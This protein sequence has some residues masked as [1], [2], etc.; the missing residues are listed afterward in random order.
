M[1]KSLLTRGVT[2]WVSRRATRQ[3]SLKSLAFLVSAGLA[4]FVP[5]ALW[6]Y[7]LNAENGLTMAGQAALS[8]AVAALTT[9]GVIHL[10]VVLPVKS[11]LDVLDDLYRGVYSTR[12]QVEGNDEIGQL[13]ERINHLADRLL[14]REESLAKTMTA[15]DISYRLARVAGDSFDEHSAKQGICATISDV[16]PKVRALFVS[17]T[18]HEHSQQSTV[19]VILA[20]TALARG[21]PTFGTNLNAWEIALPVHLGGQRYEAL[22]MYCEIGAPHPDEAMVLNIVLHVTMVIAS[23]ANYQRATT[24]GLTG[25]NNKQYGKEWLE[26]TCMEA[27]RYGHPLSLLALDIDFFK[28][29][30]DTYGHSAGD[31]VLK[32]I[33]HTLKASVRN[34]DIPI[35]N[36]G[37]EFLVVLPHTLAT[38][39]QVLAEKIRETVEKLEID[40]PTGERLNVTISI[41]VSELASTDTVTALLD[42]ADFALYDAKANGRNQVRIRKADLG[43]AHDSATKSP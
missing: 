20:K 24:D 15:L 13:G 9:I 6:L 3:S 22:V 42:R 16:Y 37:E 34:A 18:E 1:Y 8:V 5:L 33:A 31:S 27:L 43:V 26:H 30:N 28:R 12:T 11:M 38:Q 14:Q 41:G 35:R 4:I 25:L 21:S 36:G 39:A 10:W 23:A 17:S 40:V 29:V 19:P 32:L 2:A 7:Q